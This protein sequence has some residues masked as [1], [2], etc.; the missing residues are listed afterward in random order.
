MRETYEATYSNRKLNM[1]LNIKKNKICQKTQMPNSLGSER[2][3][4]V[5]GKGRSLKNGL[6]RLCQALETKT[7]R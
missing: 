2:K 4:T 7:V 1:V 5:R 3:V 6:E